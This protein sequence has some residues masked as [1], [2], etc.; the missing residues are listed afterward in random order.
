MPDELVFFTYPSS[1]SCIKMKAW[2]KK[3]N[4]QAKERHIYLDPP[5][6]QELLEII[7]KTYGLDDIL[8]TRSNKYK[9]LR[10]E[11][12]N[13][14]VSKLLE[15][16]SDEPDLLKKPIL[17]NSNHLIIGYNKIEIEKLLA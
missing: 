14:K 7:K 4:I 10:K 11:I 1:T 2:L 17:Y 12:E 6:K 8:A 15:F 16:I 3:N 13:M 9:M 5:T